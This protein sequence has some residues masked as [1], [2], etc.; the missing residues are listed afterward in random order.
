MDRPAAR[1]HASSPPV[2]DVCR[3]RRRLWWRRRHSSICAPE[4]RCPSLSVAMFPTPK[5][6]PGTSVG[7]VFVPSG[8]STITSRNHLPSL[9]RT[10]SHCPLA[11]V[12]RPAWQRPM[13]N[14]ALMRPERVNRDTRSA[15]LKL[16]IR[17]SYGIA[18]NGRKCGRLD[19]L[20]L[21]ASL[22]CAIQHTAIC[23]DS[24]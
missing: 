15:T 12:H 8:R 13:T 11:A 22:T 4:W 20:R 14:G 19:L 10:R 1:R 17:W 6:T 7:G 21:Q 5:P 24:P 3:L 2:A 23:A 9:R 16:I 18:A